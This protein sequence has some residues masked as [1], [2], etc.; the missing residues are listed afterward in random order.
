[1]IDFPKSLLPQYLQLLEKR[2]VPAKSFAECIKWSRYFLDYC[3]KYPVP[4]SDSER[5]RLFVEKLKAR[6]QSD[7][8]CKQAASPQLCHPPLA[9][10]L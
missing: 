3:N 8:Q 4:D 1:M 6:K 7:L 5:V 2:G 9:G 10:W